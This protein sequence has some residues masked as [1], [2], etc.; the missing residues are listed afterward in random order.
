M[1]LEHQLL[2]FVTKQIRVKAERLIKETQSETAQITARELQEHV[3]ELDKALESLFTDG[4]T[5]TNRRG[6]R[7]QA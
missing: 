3:A 4:G 6:R 7:S 1:S 2:S 5:V